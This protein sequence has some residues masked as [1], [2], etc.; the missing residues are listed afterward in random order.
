[1]HSHYHA[2]VWID[3]KQA[4]VFHFNAGEADKLVMHPDNPVR[5]LHHKAGSIGSGHAAE[6]Q[7]FLE[8]VAKS[9]ADAGAIVIVGPSGEKDELAKHIGQRHPEMTV[10]IEGVETVDHPTDDELLAYARR[11][12]KSADFKRPQI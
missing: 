5:H 7:R 8:E 10:K 11:Y 9:I 4:R 3:H 6:D 12:V 1:M 2:I